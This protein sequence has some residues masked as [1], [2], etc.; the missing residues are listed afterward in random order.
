[1]IGTIAADRIPSKV[2]ETCAFEGLMGYM[3]TETY[4]QAREELEH[5]VAQVAAED[6]WLREH[7]ATV[8]WLG[9]NKQGAE[10]PATHP[11]VRCMADAFGEAAGRPPVVVGFPAGCD[12][13][14]LVR[15]GGMPGLVFGPGDCTIAHS[16]DEY[17]PVSEV[18]AA[19][20]VLIVTILRWCGHRAAA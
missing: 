11:F 1:V 16:A 15:D 5:G 13:P 2:P 6:P 7:P 19:T 12:L 18:V 10:T 8:E 17:V 14:Y 9:L 3:P 4:Q 20:K